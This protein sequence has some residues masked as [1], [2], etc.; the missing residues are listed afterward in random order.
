MW[1]QGGISTYMEYLF[2]TWNILDDIDDEPL[3]NTA[4]ISDEI[5]MW[6]PNQ[7]AT[8][9]KYAK[10]HRPDTLLQWFITHRFIAAHT[11]YISVD[12]EVDVLLIVPFST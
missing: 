8:S 5:V 7:I 11:N 3:I 6:S 2:G 9:M 4:L 1:R 10:L 12:Q